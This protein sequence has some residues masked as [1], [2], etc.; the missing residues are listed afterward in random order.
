[1][2]EALT[3]KGTK[4]TE[5]RVMGHHTRGDCDIGSAARKLESKY[6]G[7][8]NMVAWAALPKQHQMTERDLQT[9]LEILDLVQKEP[10]SILMVMEEDPPWR[11]A[12]ET[13]M[14]QQLVKAL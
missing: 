13:A 9:G 2:G 14:M 12:A 11:G 4:V 7:W 5:V 10:Q 1:M 3:Q 8:I 6:K